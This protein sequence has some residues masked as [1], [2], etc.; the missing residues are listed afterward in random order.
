MGIR[1]DIGAVE[2]VIELLS[3]SHLP[4]QKITQ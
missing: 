2:F 3:A 1:Q 4:S